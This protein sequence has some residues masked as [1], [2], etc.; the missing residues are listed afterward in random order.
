MAHSR[1]RQTISMENRKGGGSDGGRNALATS[2]SIGAVFVCWFA[3][4]LVSLLSVRRPRLGNFKWAPVK[5]TQFNRFQSKRSPLKRLLASGRH[6]EVVEL[7][8]GGSII[9]LKST[10]FPNPA[11]RHRVRRRHGGYWGSCIMKYSG[12][13][14]LRFTSRWTELFWTDRCYSLGQNTA[15]FQ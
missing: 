11:H 9:R 12:I 5:P 2:R 6:W 1:Q 4:F 15:I 3:F 14:W 8:I 13:P 7:V 10:K